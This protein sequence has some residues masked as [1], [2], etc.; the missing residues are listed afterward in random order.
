MRV[1][2]NACYGCPECVNCGRNRDYYYHECD[3]CGSTE[4]LYEFEGEELCVECI[5]ERLDKVEG[6]FIY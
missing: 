3:Q 6:S 1:K 2:D 5:L 4:Q